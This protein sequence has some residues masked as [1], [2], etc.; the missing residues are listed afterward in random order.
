MVR[1]SLVELVFIDQSIADWRVIRDSLKP[2]LEVILIDPAR[3]GM[4]QI[5]AALA[6]RAGVA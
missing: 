1:D 4:L 3:D 6:G 2:D 5:A